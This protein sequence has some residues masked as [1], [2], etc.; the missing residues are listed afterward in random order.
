MIIENTSLQTSALTWYLAVGLLVLWA[1]TLLFL[2]RIRGGW[3]QVLMSLLGLAWIGFGIGIVFRFFLL[4][5]DAEAFASPSTTLA[6]RPPAVVNLALASAGVFWICFV[7]AALAARLFPVPRLLAAL[8]R[9][10]GTLAR[11]SALPT[12][13][14]SCVC[15]AAA[16]SPSTPAALVTP[17]SVLGSMWVIPATSTWIRWFRR[18]PVPSLTLVATLAPGVLQLVLS[19]YREHLLMVVLVVLVAAV[20]AGRRIRLAVVVPL[21]TVIVLLSTI[22][23]GTYREGVWWGV[24]PDDALSRVSFAQ[25]EDRPF[26]APWTAV[27]RRFHDFDSLLLTV[28][29]IPSVLPY[30]DRDVLLEGVTRAVI[31]RLVDPT[32]RASDEGLQFQ[33]MI[34]SFDDDP[35]R[36]LGT[37]SIAPSMPGS[38]YA[39]GGFAEMIGGALLWGL[40]LSFIEHL[41]KEMFSPVSAGLHVLFSV[42]ALAGIERDYSAAF[43]NMVQTFG[44]LLCVCFVLGLFELSPHQSRSEAGAPAGP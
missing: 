32:K 42:Q 17:L 9:R 20:C 18:E 11:P 23:V 31:P 27:L 6:N 25:W 1:L 37:A 5:Y 44:M 34:W 24:A 7:A 8:L 30:S 35:M 2:V 19:P 41:K 26:D 28:D 29:L 21:A 33:T 10:P 16:L 4:A 43:A 38:L 14:V 39:A 22:A 12:T 13:I 36:E 3:Q 15:I 40:L